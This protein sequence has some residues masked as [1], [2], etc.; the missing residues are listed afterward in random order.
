MALID[1]LRNALTRQWPER[2]RAFPALSLEEWANYFSFNGNIYGLSQTL[3]NA[4]AEIGANFT[5]LVQGAYK[6]NAVAYACMQAR[7]MLLSQARFQFQQMRGGRP[8]DLFGTADLDLLE[9]PEPGFVTS[10]LLARASVDVDLAGNH[11][12]AKRMVNGRLRLK[13]LRPDWVSIVLGS[14]GNPQVDTRDLDAEVLGYIY[15]PGGRNSGLPP[16]FL[17]R[18]V[19]A[20]LAPIPDP[21]HR[22]RG[23]SWLTAVISE[24]QADSAATAH[25]DLFFENGAT[26]NVVISRPD[27]PAKEAFKEWVDL[28]EEGH[29]G[30]A[31]A[32]KTL[33]LTSGATAEAIGSHFNQIDFK[34]TQGAGETR[35]ASASGVHPVIVGLSE[36]LQGSSLNQGNFMA[37][38]RLVADMTLRPWWGSFAAS[39]EILIPPPPG[40]RLW[41]DDRHIPF[42]AEDVKD[43]AEVQSLNAQSIRT[44]G[45]AGWQPDAVIDAVTAGDLRRLQG[46]H[47]GLYS[48]QLQPPQPEQQTEPL[49]LTNGQTPSEPA[50]VNNG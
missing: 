33:Y 39:L 5:G 22:Y 10:D 15:H 11:F 13:R 40:S 50:G 49:A 4:G 24:I 42:L 48:V 32:Y 34:A 19:V 25:K 28:I 46:K 18:E 8:G 6:G 1:T 37:A 16:E 43:A 31:N 17:L 21:L 35:I 29:T 20:H 45:D 7:L 47:T 2:Q 27:A 23:M 30:L 26:P 36:G 12:L 41:Y 44:L 9:H 38:R 3:V 14:N